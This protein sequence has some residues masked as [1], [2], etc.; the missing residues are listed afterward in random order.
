[1]LQLKGLGI[2]WQS[3]HSHHSNVWYFYL[4]A[5]YGFFQ[6]NL[7]GPERGRG[8]PIQIGYFKGSGPIFRA[9]IEEVPGGTAG[10][11]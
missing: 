1:M 6:T 7:D 8:Y 5:V 9:R 10:M 4:F 3:F 11:K 2:D